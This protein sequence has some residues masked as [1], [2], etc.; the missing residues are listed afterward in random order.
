MECTALTRHFGLEREAGDGATEIQ[1]RRQLV[2]L[3]IH[4]GLGNETPN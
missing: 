3:G 4:E 2:R 1:L